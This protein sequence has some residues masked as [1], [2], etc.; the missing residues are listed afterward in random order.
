MKYLNRISCIRF[1][2]NFHSNQTSHKTMV[3]ADPVK[4]SVKAPKNVPELWNMIH[5]DGA[6]AYDKDDEDLASKVYQVV[7]KECTDT[8]MIKSALRGVM[9]L[10]AP[11]KDVGT[12]MLLFVPIAYG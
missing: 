3:E 7:K 5:A 12:L 8:N 6:P 11:P 9:A 1:I 2:N 4:A 10:R